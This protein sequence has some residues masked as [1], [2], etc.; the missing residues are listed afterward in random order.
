MSRLRSETMTSIKS[1]QE[2]D[3][4]EDI[5]KRR[6]RAKSR[7]STVSMVSGDMDYLSSVMPYDSLL[8]MMTSQ[9][10]SQ[11]GTVRIQRFFICSA[12]LPLVKDFYQ[13]H[14]FLTTF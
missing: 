13:C 4:D 6:E 14:I 11:E 8:E 9:E 12:T 1:W 2:F 10:V 7:L 5:I 3:F